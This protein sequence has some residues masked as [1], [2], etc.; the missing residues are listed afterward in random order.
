MNVRAISYGGGVQSTALVVL[1]AEGIIDFHTA[2]F[3]NVGDDSEYPATLDYVR[4][5]AV[6]WGREH[7]VAVYELRKYMIRGDRAGELDTVYSR[8]VNPNLRG[9]SIPVWMSRGG[10]TNRA[11]T[12]DYKINIVGRWLKEHG[13]TKKN[14]ATVAIGISTDEWQ[15]ARSKS[16]LPFEDMVYPLL[17]LGYNRNDCEHIIK[18]AGLEV[19]PK[20]SCYF[21]PFH[22]VQKWAELKRD[23][24]DLFEKSVELE[25]IINSKRDKAGKDRVYLTRYGK[26][27]SDVITVAEPEHLES[28]DW[29]DE[30][31]ACDSGYCFT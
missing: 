24:P 5:T 29:L 11:C 30:S 26:P 22:S 28:D 23:D 10:T 14:P 25:L 12:V 19:P 4:N 3:S 18:D 15:R 31:G 6:P 16:T 1:A 27:L 13:A 20:S 21:C 7:G 9:I 8:L 17:D 2:L